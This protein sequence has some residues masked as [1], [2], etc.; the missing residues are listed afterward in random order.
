[1]FVIIGILVVIGAVVGGYLMEHGHVAVLLQPAELVIIGG[2]AIGTVLVANPLHVLKKIATGLIGVLKPSRFSRTYYLETLNMCYELLNKARKDGLVAI[3]SD[4]EE[5]DKSEVFKKYP[6]FVNDHHTRDFVCDTLRM[7]II[8]GIDPFDLDQMMESDM[9]VAHHEAS[10]PTAA[11]ST[12][13]DSLP[14]L[15]IVAAVLGVVITMGAL[16]GPPEEI[17]HKVAAALVGTFLGILLCYGF[18]GP[19][20]A[21]MAKSV[22]EEHAYHNVL[23]VLLMAFVKGNAPI[24]SLEFGRRVIPGRVRPSFQEMEKSCKR[25]A[26]AAAAAPAGAPQ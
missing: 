11:L 13:A 15:G 25:G 9:D 21:N 10:Q 23:R 16:G 12:M 2:A 14:G 6:K 3:E 17:G 7:A 5:P 19:I 18:V 24:Q 22:E 4:I 8:G 26:V 20:A 1:M